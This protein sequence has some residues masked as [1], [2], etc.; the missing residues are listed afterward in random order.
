MKLHS[1]LA[2]VALL[3]ASTHAVAGAA[4]YVAT[5]T[6]EKGE[7]E[8]EYIFGHARH[9]GASQG[10]IH[11]LVLGYG[12]TDWWASEIGLKFK[13]PP[14]ES[15]TYDAWEW[16]NRFALTEPGRYPVDIGALVEIE[17]P[18]EHSEG[19]EL[20]LGPLFQA[21]HDRWQYNA[22]V[23]FE[24][25]FRVRDGSEPKW[26]TLGQVQVKYRYR[27]PFEF[28]AQLL[29][30][31]GD[32]VTEAKAGPAIFGKLPLGRQHLKYDLALLKGL[33]ANTED[34]TLRGKIEL[35]F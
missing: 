18:R 14:G 34:T 4:D 6:I 20:K 2:T 24:K 23:L 29:S 12:L 27:A 26:K 5:P 19:Y 11:K 15:A 32:G 30:E 31:R 8:L 3:V 17:R 33:N 9:Q 16:E 10:S 28:G 25:M 7:I 35:E 22:N 13:R 1:S 21:E